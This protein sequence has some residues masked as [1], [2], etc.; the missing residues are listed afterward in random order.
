MSGWLGVEFSVCWWMDGFLA[1]WVGG[2]K[3]Q[4]VQTVHVICPGNSMHYDIIDACDSWVCLSCT[5]DNYFPRGGW[6]SPP[7]STHWHCSRTGVQWTNFGSW[8]ISHSVRQSVLSIAILLK[9][10]SRRCIAK[11]TRVSSS[12]HWPFTHLI[13]IVLVHTGG[14]WCG[15]GSIYPWYLLR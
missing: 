8:E 4:I 15:D 3:W 10:D 1:F 13:G 5:F 6:R 9:G 2:S 14:I 7:T 11:R 12:L